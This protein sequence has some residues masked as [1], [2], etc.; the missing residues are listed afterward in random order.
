MRP[1]RARRPARRP[2]SAN[3][4]CSAPPE[5]W[6][7]R[8]PRGRASRLLR[9]RPPVVAL[10]GKRG[11]KGRPHTRPRRRAGG[12]GSCFGASEARGEQRTIRD[13]TEPASPGRLGGERCP[14]PS[15]V[16]CRAPAH[17]PLPLSVRRRVGPQGLWVRGTDARAAPVARGRD[18][19]SIGAPATWPKGRTVAQK[20]GLPA[21]DPR[22]RP[23]GLVE[24]LAGPALLVFKLR[25]AW[26]TSS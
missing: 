10:P 7:R 13:T 23:R 22:R 20:N 16:T 6:G 12:G 3:P 24:S 8:P 19:T 17:E 5:L 25:A 9:S 14:A 26:R 4:A 15:A 18:S 2:G 11:V 21:P 1:S